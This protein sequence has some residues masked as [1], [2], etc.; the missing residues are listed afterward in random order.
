MLL[1]GSTSAC[2]S[3]PLNSDYPFSPLESLPHAERIADLARLSPDVLDIIPFSKFLAEARMLYDYSGQR[4]I[5]YR[6]STPYAYV[7]SLRSKL[8]GMM[9]SDIVS[10]VNSYPRALAIDSAGNLLDYSAK[11]N[12]EASTVGDVVSNRIRPSLSRSS[13]SS[14][15][16]SSA[17][18]ITRPLSL[19]AHDILKTVD[20][21]IQRG[22]FRPDHV[23]SI[24]YGSRDL[25]SWHLVSSSTSARITGFRGT[26]YKYF[27]IALIAR[28][29]PH[30]SIS[31]CS[32][33]FTPRLTNRLR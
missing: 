9:L 10:S 13:A 18:L 25:H 30:E 24:L 22:H 32:A 27:R 5:L 29:S 17:I 23:S 1:S 19:D 12:P 2:I 6:P 21:V 16:L 7:Y 11:S 15:M 20:T 33:S 31:G 3:D 8:W 4:V 14:P 28:L 26:P